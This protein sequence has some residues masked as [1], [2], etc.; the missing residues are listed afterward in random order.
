VFAGCAVQ[1]AAMTADPSVAFLETRSIP[2][3]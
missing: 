3:S 2:Q 1:P